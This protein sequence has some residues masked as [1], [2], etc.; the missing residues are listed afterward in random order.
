M[1]WRSPHQSDVRRPLRPLARVL[2]VAALGFGAVLLGSSSAGAQTPSP[3]RCNV[4]VLNVCAPLA[5]DGS[6]SLPVVPNRTSLQRVR[7]TCTQGTNTLAGQSAF[8]SL[9]PSGAAAFPPIDLNLFEPAPESLCLTAE[10]N[11]TL[12]SCQTLAAPPGLDAGQTVQ[13]T[14]LGVFPSTPL[15]K[16]LSAAALGTSYTT[17]NPNIATVDDH[18][19]VTAVGSG[20][21]FIAA[22]NEGALAS[23]AV[24]VLADGDTD[25]DGLPDD[26]ELA[27]GL[28]PANPNDAALD[29]DTDGLTN[30]QE[31]AAGT[32]PGVADT[33]GD[34][35]DD[36]VETATGSPTLALNPD[37]DGDGL[38][39]GLEAPA[40]GDP[41]NPDSDGDG[42]PDGVEVAIAGNAAGANPLD[43]FDRDALANIDEV[44]LFTDPTQVDTDGDG[45]ADGEEVAAPATDPLDFFEPGPFVFA[46]PVGLGLA[47]GANLGEV[48][49]APGRSRTVTLN[50]LE[51]AAATDLVV[52]IASDDPAVVT[53]DSLVTIPA[54]STT[55]TFSLQTAASPGRANLTFEAQGNRQR[56]S[57][58]VGVEPAGGVHL[59]FAKPVGL[60]LA[61]GASLGEVFMAPGR[62]RT[63][64]LELLEQPATTETLV[65]LASSDPLVAAV[66]GFVTVPTGSTAATF[67]IEAGGA[68]GQAVLT[69]SAGVRR[70]LSIT[71]GPRANPEDALIFAPPLGLETILIEEGAP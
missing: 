36:A 53:T 69:L 71:V 44:E 37:S 24:Q 59:V 31:F 60:G 5:A 63:V 64:T 61:S 52:G 18:G 40:G 67:T 57:V 29:L 28:D 16:N 4:C 13:L 65:G 62:N 7:I 34:G 14:T 42:L 26:Y 1:S 68:S 46:S 49:V 12:E 10:A 56:L 47:A 2:G 20:T 9:A 11:P 19:L 21:A 51:Q 35:L 38:L 55:A 8:V 48:L 70:S 54:G 25:G 17:S 58:A 33:D 15:G 66:P 41:A 43:D 3:Q 50:L 23:L 30:L 22:L 27:N 45:F 6:W 39:D 32:L